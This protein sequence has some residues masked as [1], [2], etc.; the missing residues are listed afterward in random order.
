MAYGGKQPRATL[1]DF[2][3]DEQTSSNDDHVARGAN[4]A[5]AWFGGGYA[6]GRGRHQP[7]GLGLESASLIAAQL[8]VDHMGPT[9]V[10]CC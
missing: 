5:H 1:V 9:H 6:F 10:V 7:P 3:A 2:L 4:T 8:H